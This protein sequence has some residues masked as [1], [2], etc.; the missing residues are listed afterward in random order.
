MNRSIAGADGQQTATAVE[1]A[2][3]FILANLAFGSD[4]HIE[5]DVSV[6][7]VQAYIG[8]QFAGNFERNIAVASLQSPACGQCRPGCRADFYVSV[9][10]LQLEF[11]EAPLGAD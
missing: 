2:V 11:I 10:R 1:L 3:N 8:R 9:T 5:I 4:G 7:G 6:A